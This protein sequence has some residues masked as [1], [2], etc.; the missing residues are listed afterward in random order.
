MRP[1]HT[2]TRDMPMLHSIRRILFH[3]REDIAYDSGVVV[4]RLLR[5]RD[6]DCDEGELRPGEG[7]IEVI[8]HEVACGARDQLLFSRLVGKWAYFSGRLVMFAC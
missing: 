3:F 5:S 7:M 8:F 6:I 1:H 2:Q 4:G